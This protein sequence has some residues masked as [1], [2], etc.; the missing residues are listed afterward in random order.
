MKILLYGSTFLTAL[1]E[2]GIQEH[3]VIGHVPSKHPIFKG[4]M[5]SVCYDENFISVDYDIAISVQYD[6]KITQLDNVYNLHT[7]LLPRY[8]GCDILYH[9][10]ENG[11][12]EQGLT[13]H[14]I[15]E[16]F[17]YGQIIS[18]ITYPVL[19]EDRVVDLY[20]KM[21]TIAPGFVNSCLSLLEVSTQGTE[22]IKPHM[23]KRGYYPK[24]DVLKTEKY[25]TDLKEILYYVKS[26]SNRLLSESGKIY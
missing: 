23:Y 20:H 22:A 19:K 10:K 1:V 3:T 5:Q 24:G 6:R 15:T 2:R 17:D 11:E 8:G 26:K 7:G 4:E 18:K 25:D 21:C 14:K 9:T 12:K 13:F 16:E